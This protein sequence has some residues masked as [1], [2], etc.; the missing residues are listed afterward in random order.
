MELVAEAALERDG[1]GEILRG[2][3]SDLM[4]GVVTYGQLALREQMRRQFPEQAPPLSTTNLRDSARDEAALR[5]RSVFDQL[6]D[7]NP[8]VFA[9]GGAA[10]VALILLLRD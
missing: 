7:V 8:W 10:V 1:Y 6:G 4:D 3:F 5:N 9:L 2:G